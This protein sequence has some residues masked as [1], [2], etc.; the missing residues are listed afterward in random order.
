[1]DATSPHTPPG[2]GGPGHRTER[3]QLVDEPLELGARAVVAVF[4]PE[5]GEVLHDAE[6]RLRQECHVVAPDLAALHGLLEDRAQIGHVL[7]EG[8]RRQA[9]HRRVDRAAVAEVEEARLVGLHEVE[10]G[11]EARCIRSM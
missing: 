9:T 3:E 5:A 6:G 4:H 1:V 10:V 2:A 11:V 8:P 7:V